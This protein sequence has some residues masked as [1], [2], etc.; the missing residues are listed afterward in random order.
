M[1]KYI[2]SADQKE[3]DKYPEINPEGTEI[4]TPNERKFKI[5]LIK[6]LNELQGNADR[7]NKFRIYLTTEIETIKKNQSKL[8]EMKTQWMR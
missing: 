3:N 1:K 8:L 6:Q 2:K 4:Y 7:L 5:A